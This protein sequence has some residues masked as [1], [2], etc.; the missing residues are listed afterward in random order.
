MNP[1]SGFINA[2]LNFAA[3]V[4]TGGPYDYKNQSGPGTS[5]QRT[6]AGNIAYGVS[7]PFGNL[8]CQ[9]AAGLNQLW[10]GDAGPASSMFHDPR[11]H[12]MIQ[13]GQAMKAAGCR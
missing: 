12:A 6:D 5:T 4:Q 3:L 11:D 8:F 10:R 1:A 9:A 7:C 2:L 13:Q